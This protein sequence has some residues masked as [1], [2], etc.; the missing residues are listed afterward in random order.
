[1]ILFMI[2]QMVTTVLNHDKVWWGLFSGDI[3][4]PRTHFRHT[5]DKHF[6]DS[7]DGGDDDDGGDGDDDAIDADHYGS[8]FWLKASISA[9]RGQLGGRNGN[10]SGGRTVAAH[11]NEVSRIH[12]PTK[13]L[14]ETNKNTQVVKQNIK[15]KKFN[16]H[17]VETYPT[18]VS[19][20]QKLQEIH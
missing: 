14:Q 10:E 8:V 4:K 19:I 1:M 5:G 13:S 15:I 3:T 20:I 2:V 6:D 9:C 7:D 18:K 12:K 16:R 11:P 17:A